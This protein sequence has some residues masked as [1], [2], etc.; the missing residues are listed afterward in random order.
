MQGCEEWVHADS[1]GLTQGKIERQWPVTSLYSFACTAVPGLA[2]TAACWIQLLLYCRGGE[3]MNILNTAEKL[4]LNVCVCRWRRQIIHVFIMKFGV[5]NI[6]TSLRLCTDLI[7]LAF[8]Q[9]KDI[10]RL[11]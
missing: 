7:F 11:P 8:A 6:D 5:L 1:V 2:F 4:L 9:E 10:Y 3:V